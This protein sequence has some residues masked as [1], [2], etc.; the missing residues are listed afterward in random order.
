MVINIM[1]PSNKNK[2]YFIFYTRMLKRFVLIFARYSNAR[3]YIGRL[4]SA[5]V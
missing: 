2:T 4:G 1:F 3:R 5:V